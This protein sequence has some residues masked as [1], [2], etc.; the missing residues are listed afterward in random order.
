MTAYRTLNVD[1]ERWGD[2]AYRNTQLMKARWWARKVKATVIIWKTFVKPKRR[3][4]IA[5][6]V[7]MP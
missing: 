6:I 2:P 1:G 7:W 3:E 5:E 4:K